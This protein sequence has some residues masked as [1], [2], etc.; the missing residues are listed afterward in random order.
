[1]T[2]S[3][4]GAASLKGVGLDAY[5]GK[6][7]SGESPDPQEPQDTPA[8]AP[9]AEGRGAESERAV[10]SSLFGDPNLRFPQRPRLI[11][12]VRVFQLPD[13]LGIQ[14][15]SGESPVT[16]RGA[17]TDRVLEFLLPRLTG[18]SRVED[19]VADCPADVPQSTLVK[20]LS[21]LHTKGLLADADAEQV[22]T[23]WS[24]VVPATADQI[25]HRQ[26]LFWGR[27]VDVTR[28]ARSAR[29]V[30]DR[31]AGCRVGLVATGTFGA[32]THDLL[33][34]T[35]CR[36]LCVLAWD[37]DGGLLETA[38]LAP[39]APRET[40]RLT[41]TS[42]LEVAEPLRRWMDELDLVITATRNAPAE[43]FRIVNRICLQRSMRWLRANVDATRIEVG[44]FVYPFSSACFT[45]L[46]LRER[47][48]HESAIE[49]HLYQED[50]AQARPAGA[51]P[52]LGEALFCATLGASVLVG[53]V[54]RVATGLA[55]PTLLNAVMTILPVTGT[56]ERNGVLRVPRCPECYRGAV[57]PPVPQQTHG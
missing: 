2:P 18:S 22:G 20:T 3:V 48:M 41:T 7:R 53:E 47:S 19:L 50:L 26:L 46:E 16:F 34:R 27:H 13:G 28:A 37:D 39:V 45:C 12:D 33:V 56:F 8:P 54:V 23:G 38:A 55:P 24:G 1:M 29:D 52:P 31:L 25:L 10:V 4:V 11:Q 21:L 14:F 6:E 32:V 43:L 42:P 51:T 30:Q 5:R 57:P 49:E 9:E 36:D 15:R 35:G 44:P 40:V 17:G